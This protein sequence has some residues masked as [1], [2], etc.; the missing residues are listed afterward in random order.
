M[1][2]FI[3]ST[4]LIHKKL[5]VRYKQ[6]KKH[7]LV[8]NPLL[9]ILRYLLLNIF[10][11]FKTKPIIWNWVNNIKYYLMI[12]DSCLISNCYFYIDD[13]EEI[14]FMINYLDKD[15]TF[16]DIG[17]NH[18]N[19]TLLSSCIVGC[20][21]ISV[22]P[23]K[24]TLNR[25]KMNLNLNNCKNVILRQ[26]GIS[27]K[28]GEL[29][30]SNDLGE[31]NKVIENETNQPT[32]SV[33]VITLDKLL[34]KEKNISMI[35]IDVEGY[36]KN[37]LLGGAKS[38]KNKKLDVIQIELNNSNNFYNYDEKETILIL[39]DYGF[40]PYKYHPQNKKL[41]KLNGKNTQR[42]DTLFIR[43]IERVKNK[44]NKRTVSIDNKK[45]TVK[46]H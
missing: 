4:L 14:S 42:R 34:S 46:N 17:S 36:E 35:K 30:F 1:I 22:E 21:T 43:N 7:P 37:I 45:I 8:I 29:A 9:G 11:R 15:E 13:Y 3:N 24:S 2:N 39:K 19:Y 26:V 10:L 31:C 33:K 12:G 5:I 27:D 25:L 41:L 40:L 6:L 18:G 20:K 28:E 44:L 32:E 23:I 38:L 16:V